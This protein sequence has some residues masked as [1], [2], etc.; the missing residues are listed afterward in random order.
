[1]KRKN[2]AAVALGRN[3]GKAGSGKAKARSS[4]A[5]KA[6]VLK[7]WENHWAKTGRPNPAISHAAT[8]AGRSP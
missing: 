1:M 4:E 6:A 5:A 8:D 7:R 3:G 2:P